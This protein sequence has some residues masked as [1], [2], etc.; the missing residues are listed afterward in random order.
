MHPQ[1]FRWFFWYWYFLDAE[2]LKHRSRCDLVSNCAKV[3]LA[4]FSLV[5]PD[6]TK[7]TR[8]QK[9]SPGGQLGKL[10]DKNK[11]RRLAR[12]RKGYPPWKLTVCTWKWMVGILV[13]SWGPAYF[14]GH[15]SPRVIRQ[16]ESR[17]RERLP[18]RPRFELHREVHK[19]GNI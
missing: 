5:K 10:K 8:A 18:R 12:F 2:I 11:T 15:L 3:A 6:F 19:T 13:S 7:E 17:N 1:I 16:N 4:S 14:Q 9:S